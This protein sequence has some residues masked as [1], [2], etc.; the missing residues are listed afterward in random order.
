V[1]G[2]G[3]FGGDGRADILWRGQGGEIAVWQMDGGQVIEG[4][5]VDANPGAYWEISP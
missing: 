2:T 3:D 5:V 4:S 1:A